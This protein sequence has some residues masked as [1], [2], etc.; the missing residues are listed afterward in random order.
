MKNYIVKTIEEYING[1]LSTA[2][3]I[4]KKMNCSER[5]EVLSGIIELDMDTALF[6]T[7]MYI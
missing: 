5:A 3:D 6:L 7:R 2:R 1:N 4:F